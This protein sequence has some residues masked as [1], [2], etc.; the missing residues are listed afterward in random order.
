MRAP[1]AIFSAISQAPKSSY[2]SSYFILLL[3]P[4]RLFFDLILKFQSFEL[5]K[6]VK[7]S[8]N[9]EFLQELISD[10][11]VCKLQNYWGAE[12]PPYNM[13]IYQISSYHPII[14]S[15]SK[16]VE[17]LFLKLRCSSLVCNHMPFEG[18][19]SIL[20]IAIKHGKS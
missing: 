13:D 7:F 1:M 5:D 20:V 10:N 19:I 3:Y 8:Y 15:S 18:W 17:P 16:F 9:I 4:N 12:A 11:P 2:C 14:I 6:L